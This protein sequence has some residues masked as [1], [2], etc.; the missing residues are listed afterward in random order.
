MSDETEFRWAI[1]GTGGVARKFV[2]DLRHGGGSA[3]VVASR[4]P[5]NAR[6]FAATLPVDG[7][8][9]DYAAAVRAQVDAVYVATPPDLHEA[10][11]LMAIEAGRAVLVEKPFA[12]SAAAAARIAAAAREAGVFCMEAMWT[13]FQPV[14]GAVRRAVEDGALGEPR[15]FEA[16]FCAA[17]LPEPGAGLF[18]PARGG[19]A[20][21]H[22]G[23][24]PLSLARHLM[25]PVEEMTATARIGETG[26]DEDCVLTLRHGSGALS[27]VR[28]GLRSGGAEGATLSG[29]RATLHLAGPVYRPTAAWIVPVRP[30]PAATGQ[31]G[32]RRLEAFRESA[33][34]LRLSRALSGLGARRARRAL[35]AAMR[36]NGYH[37]QAAAV[38]DAVRAGRL[39]E[40]RMPPSESVEIMELVDRARAEWGMPA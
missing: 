4:D 5:G 33:P 40:P 28:A 26:V 23:V 10:H 24:Y 38:R 21:M 25:G 22:R 39:D 16:R 32:A 17:N 7:A 37:Y 20:L 34:G 14:T 27:V 6:R 30:M 31:A 18:D 13:R 3:R 11:A 29:T 35:P 2:L 1:L 12:S 19:G 8:A 36:G 15:S 9:P